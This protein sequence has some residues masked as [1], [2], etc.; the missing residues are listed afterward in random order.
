MDIRSIL[1]HFTDE[2]FTANLEM[3]DIVIQSTTPDWQPAELPYT[4]W[5]ERE[6]EREGEGVGGGGGKEGRERGDRGRE[7]GERGRRDKKL[8]LSSRVSATSEVSLYN[9]FS[10]ITSCSNL[11]II[12]SSPTGTR[13]TT[14]TR[15]LPSRCALGAELR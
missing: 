12:I 11:F 15:W 3:T 6:G 10:T 5:R 9:Y 1:V 8:T 7:G 13:S 2:T 14:K 4:R